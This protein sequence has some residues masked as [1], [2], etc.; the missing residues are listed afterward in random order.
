MSVAGVGCVCVFCIFFLLREAASVWAF[1]FGGLER[2]ESKEC[3][4]REQPSLPKDRNLV[5]GAHGS[6]TALFL[7][8]ASSPMPGI[9]SPQSL[10]PRLSSQV[11]DLL[12]PPFVHILPPHG[13]AQGHSPGLDVLSTLEAGW[14]GRPLCGPRPGVSLLT[15]LPT[16]HHSPPPRHG[17]S[18][19]PRPELRVTLGVPGS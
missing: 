18:I 2:R 3:L 14:R 16:A 12:P 13:T 11:G 15:C 19:P 8:R 4:K 10:S 9:P 1:C 7:L 6:S 5:L 17:Q